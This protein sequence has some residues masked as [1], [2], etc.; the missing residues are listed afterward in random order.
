MEARSKWGMRLGSF[1]LVFLFCFS[2]FPVTAQAAPVTE[3]TYRIILGSDVFT[4]QSYYNTSPVYKLPTNEPAVVR[5]LLLPSSLNGQQNIL[6]TLGELNNYLVNIGGQ[7][8]FNLPPQTGKVQ[9]PVPTVPTKPV[10]P[11]PAVVGASAQET[12][13]LTMINS[14]RAKAGVAPLRMNAELVKVAR[15]K[16]QDMINQKYFAHTSPT[17]GDPFAMMR[18]FGINYRYAGENLA[19]NPSLNGAHTSLMN[20]PGH[21]Q[22]ILNPNYTQVGIGIIA[23]GPYGCM[24]TQLFIG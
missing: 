14:E 4:G 12:Q 9:N 19:G 17:Y 22:N 2:L 20:S 18:S 6:L 21:R 15:L 10:E 24:F 16:S 13:M 7:L 5:Y 23:G 3:V 1:C 11:P 8:Y